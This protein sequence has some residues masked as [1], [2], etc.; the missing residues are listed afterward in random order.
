MSHTHYMR[1]VNDR[2]NV[3]KLTVGNKHV[4]G[5]KSAVDNVHPTVLSAHNK[6]FMYM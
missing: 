1:N 6:H 2:V 4:T 5:H 3:V